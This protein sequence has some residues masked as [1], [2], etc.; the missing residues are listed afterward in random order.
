MS[1]NKVLR[2]ELA[3]ER[4]HENGYYYSTLDLPAEEYEIQDALQRARISGAHM[5]HHDLSIRYCEDIPE[6]Q[7]LRL[8]APTIDELNFLSWRIAG[9]DFMERRLYAS[10]LSQ[11]I[12]NDDI[13]SM[14]TLINCTY[15]LDEV[16]VPLLS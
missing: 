13:V 4:S 6:L 5:N 10:V 3:R 9:M 7:D 8:D 14:K 15:N 1:D 11:A 2:I 16:P 12:G